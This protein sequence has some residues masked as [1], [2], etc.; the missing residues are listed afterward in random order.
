[1][2]TQH[3][4]KLSAL[5]EDLHFNLSDFMLFY[6]LHTCFSCMIAQEETRQYNL[7]STKETVQFQVQI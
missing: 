6:I 7:H 2:G 1:M 5:L 3:Q 4:K